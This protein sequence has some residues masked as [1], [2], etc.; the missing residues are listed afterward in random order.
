MICVNAG[1][2]RDIGFDLGLR[3]FE[4]ANGGR[5]GQSASQSTVAKK[6]NIDLGRYDRKSLL[7]ARGEAVQGPA[8]PA[9]RKARLTI[10]RSPAADY[11]WAG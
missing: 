7:F 1:C 4:I 3:R 6:L 11:L 9:G 10:S 5:L 2:F 8:Q